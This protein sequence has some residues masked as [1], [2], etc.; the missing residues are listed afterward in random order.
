[1]LKISINIISLSGL[2]LGLGMMVDNSII[3]IDNIT[4]RWIKGEP[5]QDACVYGTQEVFTP[6]AHTLAIRRIRI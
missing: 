1:M 4:Q 6:F 3:T 5:L 2:V